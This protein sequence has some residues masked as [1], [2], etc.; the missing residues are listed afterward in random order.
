MKSPSHDELEEMIQS[1]M[2][3][4]ERESGGEFDRYAT[5]FFSTGFR[6]GVLAMLQRE[7]LSQFPTDKR[8]EN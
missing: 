2:K 1:A 5:A 6:L 8:K 4:L 7:V 3:E